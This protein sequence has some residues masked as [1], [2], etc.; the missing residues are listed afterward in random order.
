MEYDIKARF[1]IFSPPKL[2]AQTLELKIADQNWSREFYSS[3]TW[4]VCCDDMGDD[5]YKS[6]Q[7]IKWHVNV[8]NTCNVFCDR[9]YKKHEASI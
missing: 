7:M 4:R 5:D 8:D 3:H 2:M 1:I 6:W 9:V